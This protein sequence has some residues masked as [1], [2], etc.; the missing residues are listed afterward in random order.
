[1]LRSAV[2][3][4]VLAVGLAPREAARAASGFQ[5]VDRPEQGTADLLYNGQPALRYMY[6]FD[7]SS[8]QRIE[9]TFRV[10]HQVFGPGTGEAITKGAGGYEPH[11]R[12]LFVGW[13]DTIVEGKTLNTWSRARGK[14][15]YQRHVRF[16]EQKADA[17][18][19]SMTSEITWNDGSD[20]PFLDEIRAVRVANVGPTVGHSVAPPIWQIDW[21]STLSSRRGEIMLRGDRQHAGFQFRAAQEVAEKKSATYIRPA[22][23]P[24]EPKPF[25]VDDRKNPDRHVNLGWFAMSYE[26]KR[27]RYTVAYFQ[28]PA[29]PKPSMFSERPYGRFGAYFPANV[30]PDKPLTLR[31]R[32]LVFTGK[33][34]ARDALQTRYD[35]FVAELARSPRTAVS[36]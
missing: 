2:L 30:T 7:P 20:K 13:R 33:P 19:G 11:H 28:D 29:L 17:D 4:L 6:A 9:D 32:L 3:L 27:T 14:E 15:A 36:K 1:M 31:Y 22:G 12:G 5:W 34:P 21:T 23:F 26:A 8:P 10:F 24:Q 35:R 25:E 18:S 16:L